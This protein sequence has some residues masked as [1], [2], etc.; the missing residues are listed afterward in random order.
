VINYPN[1]H[2]IVF[3]IMFMNKNKI[4]ILVF[5]LAILFPN[6]I[7]LAAK[8]EQLDKTPI[9]GDYV[10]GPG[11]NE[12]RLN[13]GEQIVKI[14]TVTNRYGKEMEF[15]IEIED[16]AGS[17]NVQEPLV[18]LGQEKGP[19]SLRDFLHPETVEF[20][21]QHGDRISVPITIIIPK[22]SQP[23]GLYGSIIVSTKPVVKPN[24][25]DASTSNGNIT[26]VSRL[27]SLFF[28]RVN[29]QVKEEGKISN[30]SVDK[31]FYTQPN[32]IF[33]T[34]FENSG[35]IYLNPYGL[36]KIENI[37][38]SKVD[39]IKIDPYF[40]MPGSVRQKEFITK[41]SIMFGRY[42]A[43]LQM[44]RGYENIVDE[45]AVFFWVL[46]WKIVSMI[47][48]IVFFVVF[49]SKTAFDWLKNNFEIK[50]KI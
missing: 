1:N 24:L 35:N 23:G 28:V 2:W 41:R 9:A 49:I 12:I 45:R 32:I 50:R 46:P 33:K 6:S 34:L 44:N 47:I 21:L 10:I 38:G 30:F 11:K 18:L 17:N 27:A 3:V 40:V 48:L 29:G 13:P 43:T 25:I 15:K 14:L 4:F 5:A 36:L 31:S 37:I 42:K 7:V 22:D 16:F 39:E 26:I 20:K 8:I 19:Y